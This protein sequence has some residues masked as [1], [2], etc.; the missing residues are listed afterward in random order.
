MPSRIPKTTLLDLPSEIIKQIGTSVSTA[1]DLSHFAQASRALHALLEPCLYR[2]NVE[3]GK[4]S[5]S[6]LLWALTSCTLPEDARLRVV[7]KAFK[8]GADVNALVRCDIIELFKYLTPMSPHVRRQIPLLAVALNSGLLA[9]CQMLV[10]AGA[11]INLESDDIVPP[12]W[13]AVVTKN[14]E[15]VSFL[16]VQPGLIVKGYLPKGGNILQQAVTFS[17][18]QIVKC[19]LHYVEDPNREDI[20]GYTPLL[21]AVL[22]QKPAMVA[23][24]LSSERL[25]PDVPMN[26]T[27]FMR[28]G[29]PPPEWERTIFVEACRQPNLEIVRML[30]DDPRVDVNFASC[31][32]H[33]PVQLAAMQRRKANVDFLLRSP[34]VT[35]VRPV[36]FEEA[37]KDRCAHMAMMIVEFAG[38]EDAVHAEEWASAAREAGLTDVAEKIDEK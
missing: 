3:V 31:S 38:D 6:A 30:H 9:A 22:Y 4:G 18:P 26:R 10:D 12:L 15:A 1:A 8:G 32:P 35:A 20:E 17:T 14:A 37:C 34:K 16:L 36:V 5:S 33:D 11:D 13:T 27:V 7:K 23:A 19:L 2:H 28:N 25:R 24:L 21:V 29:A